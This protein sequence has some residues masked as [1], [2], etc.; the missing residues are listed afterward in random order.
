[1]RFLRKWI[2]TFDPGFLIVG[3]LT[4]IALWP[5]LINASLPEGTDAELHI[6]RLAELSY[7]LRGGEI[8]PRWAPNFFHGFGYPIFNYYAPFT[9]YLGSLVEFLPRVDVVD[10]VKTLF[11]GGMLL[12]AVGMYGFVRDNWGRRAGYVATAV[13]IYAP[14][15]QYIDPHV[16]GVLPESFSF[17]I[18]ALALWAVD[19][20]A[21]SGRRWPWLTAVLATAA[22]IMTHNLMGL[23]FFSWLFAWMV[24]RIFGRRYRS[25]GTPPGKL[26]LNIIGSQIEIAPD[27]FALCGLLLSLGVAAIF[28]LPVLLESSAVNLNTLIGQENN[29]DFHSHFIT[30]TELL[31]PSQWIDWGAAQ[32]A[33]RFNLGVAQWALGLL[34]VVMLLLRK[35]KHAWHFSFF[36]FSLAVFIFLM[37]PLSVFLW[38]N[39]PFL[40]FFQF[41]WRLLGPAAAMLAVV[42]GVGSGALFDLI[43]AKRSGAQSKNRLTAWLAGLF[44][45][46]PLLL[47]IPLSQVAP[48][49]EFGEVFTLR[50]SL[51]ENSGRWLGTTS[52]DDY[53]PNTVDI[54]PRRQSS[55]VDNFKNGL[56]PDHINHA[57]LPEGS[58]IETETIRPLLTRYYTNTPRNTL[59]R[60][61]LFD[62]PGWQARIDGEPVEKQL[63]R[64]EGFLVIPL[65]AGEHVVEVEFGSTPARDLATLLTLLALLSMLYIA[66]VL[67]RQ[68]TDYL[69]LAFGRQHTWRDYRDW[70]VLAVV[71]FVTAVFV[72]LNTFGLFHIESSGNTVI[73]AQ[74]QTFADFDHSIALLGFDSPNKQ[75][76]AG[77]ELDLMLYWKAQQLLDIN[78]Q[79]FVHI[80]DEAGN[81]VAQSDKLNPGDFPTRRWT[82]D[83]YIQDPHELVLPADLPAGTYTVTA[84][85]WVQEEGWRSPLVDESGI[86]L[87]DKY[88]L[89]TFT[90]P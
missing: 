63:G 4:L 20:L 3:M 75:I 80:F 65:P 54:I 90:I 19:R 49:P 58:T 17:G 26:S 40:P 79:V 59:L 18:F 36:V 34:G 83:K 8:Y 64:P 52:T 88:T 87:D 28:W 31:T 5:F 47:A 86:Q 42:A 55:V 77:D 69:P 57:M 48:W 2:S 71:V 43:D 14:Y 37:L 44:V 74:Q 89:Y 72:I 70:P 23:L 68:G 82:T 60:L 51:I 1:M 73:P 53:I 46:V 7:L 76:D 10:A 81:L 32:P 66:V 84:G 29:Y 61:F 30:V 27:V 16:R 13:F 39:A 12:A 67:P 22:L 21:R 38:E 56:P 15:I 45:A 85:L 33:F 62:F 9:Y 25:A 6:F 11:M 35:V 24:W 50:M 41:P 78:Y